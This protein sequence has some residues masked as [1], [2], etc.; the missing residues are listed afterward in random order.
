M[1]DATVNLTPFRKI[2][3]D[4]LRDDGVRW[5]S[6]HDIIERI[7]GDVPGRRYSGLIAA[8]NSALRYLLYSGLVGHFQTGSG[9]FTYTFWFDPEWRENSK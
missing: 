5:L 8:A 2:I 4:V 9:R 6:A 1:S 7:Y 3:L